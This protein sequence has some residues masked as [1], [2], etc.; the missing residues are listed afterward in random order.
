VSR[1]TR[2]ADPEP[3][4][5]RDA[6]L[7]AASRLLGER[8][9]GELSVADIIGAAGVSRASFYF[10]FD[11]K[12]DVLAELVRQAVTAGHGEA[13]PWLTHRGVA[14]RRDAIAAGIRG[15]ARLW[16]EQAPVLRA[17][18][19]NWQSDRR[20]TELW[21]SQM[22][23][24]TAVTEERIL[25]DRAADP[26]LPHGTDAH[27]LAASLTWLGERLYYLAA[28]ST[29]PFQDQDTLIDTLVYIWTAVLYPR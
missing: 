21:L 14:Q 24:Y 17:I 26:D 19:E 2:E 1:R 10:Y 13:G 6:I 5:V 18:V 29:P 8:R 7:H 25:L 4:R 15:G 27:A 22:D 3:G 23:S 9:F 16:Q 11:G 28:T 12:Y 20:L